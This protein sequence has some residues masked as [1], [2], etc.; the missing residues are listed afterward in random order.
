MRIGGLASGMDI[1]SLVKDLMKAE[2]L[3]MDKLTQK[4]QVLEWQ[5]DDYRSMNSLLL[6]LRNETFNMKLSSTY[7]SRVA[8]SSNEDKITATATSV[9]GTSSY[10]ISEVKQLATAATRVGKESISS[11]PNQKVDVNK[12]LYKSFTDN[13]FSNST[14]NWTSGSVESQTISV[15]ADDTKFELTL[16]DS[17]VKLKEP[18]NTVVKVDGKVYEYVNSETFEEGKNQVYVKDNGELVF[19][20]TIKKGSQIKVDYIANKRI[21]TFKPAEATKEI[22]LTKDSIYGEE[23]LSIVV[24]GDSYTTEI[25][26]S[27]RKAAKLFLNG[28]PAGTI[29]LETGTIKFN[30]EIA[31]D[32]EIKVTYK[33][34][35][36][37]FDLTT[38][39]SKGKVTEKF[40]VQGSESLSN[41]L[42]KINSSEVGLTAFYDSY[43]DKI[44]LTRKETGNFNG[45]EPEPDPADT[46]PSDGITM[47][48]PVGNHEII[49]SSGFLND[50]LKFANSE[51]LGGEN[52][53]FTINGLETQRASNT[54]EMSG[55][56]FTL[57]DK[58]KSTDPPVSI[59]ISNNA[60][61]V[62][63]NI[64]KYVE[65][66][67]ETIA[68][69]Q[70]KTS[71]TKYRDYQ[72]LTDE[73]REGLSDKQQEMWEEKAKSGLLRRD[74]ILSNALNQFRSAFYN[75][76]MNSDIDPN[77]KQ[78]TAIGITT[79]PNYL[80]GGKLIIDEAKL[81]KAIEE[82]PEAI[83]KLFM[84][85]GTTDGEKGIATR[86]YDSLSAS[87]DK[88]KERAG[89]SLS[90]NKQ[91]TIG[92]TLDDLDKRIDA[93]QDRLT[94]IEDRYWRQ[95]TAMEKAIQQSNSQSTYLMQQFGM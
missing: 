34:N 41:V 44:T 71:E 9:A 93:F 55:V 7:R 21:D 33:Q 91:F 1:D 77:M 74:P 16:K 64:K 43:T 46:D 82:N 87:M 81:K 88:I 17:T 13:D 15:D 8:T 35:Y 31:K 67:N 58:F 23:S 22:Q 45:G 18:A 32:T 95:F 30:N 78:L 72:P 27:D 12:S 76:V 51:E 92:K 25:N 48:N 68:K 80:E 75:P 61:A 89:N 50:V 14:F 26:P 84:S 2:R 4:K 86:L 63:D 40:N 69:I 57:K 56:T 36:F 62:F 37:S 90:T 65:K 24:G 10:S 49:T 47:L 94:Q 70:E 60:T 66:Y 42:N 38:H 29:D 85:T 19:S 28:N 52:A 3:P 54:F 53:I 11:N 79:S 83:E 5:R 59:N 6:T 73:E 39:T 20:N